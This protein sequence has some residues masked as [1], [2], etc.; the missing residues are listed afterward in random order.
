MPAEPGPDSRQPGLDEVGRY[1][2]GDDLVA[3]VRDDLRDARP[4]RA[5]PDN[6]DRADPVRHA[7]D[8]TGF[9]NHANVGDRRAGVRVEPDL[10][11]AEPLEELAVSRQA[12]ADTEPHP[13]AAGRDRERLDLGDQA[14]AEPASAECG[15]DG[16]PPEVDVIGV[17]AVEHAGGDP[18]VALAHQDAAQLQ[19]VPNP[20]GIE[21]ERARGRLQHVPVFGERRADHARDPGRLGDIRRA[22]GLTGSCHD[23]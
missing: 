6:A 2:A 4:H 22:D 10:A 19:Q 16:Q 9:S 13:V 15:D 3:V 17:R 14:H 20:C 7:R 23:S 1:L 11:V 21:G 8:P 18:P 12:Q 5:Q